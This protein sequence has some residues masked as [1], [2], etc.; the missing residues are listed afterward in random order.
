[1][2]KFTVLLVVISIVG[3]LAACTEN[4]ASSDQADTPATSQAT[5][6][7]PTTDTQ[8]QSP[9]EEVLD[10]A[11]LFQKYLSSCIN[12][13]HYSFTNDTFS[14]KKEYRIHS[15]NDL[16]KDGY[17]FVDVDTKISTGVT[18]VNELLEQGWELPA[19]LTPEQ[20]IGANID[21][22]S[23]ELT[24]NGHTIRV[25]M[26]N[27]TDASVSLKDAKISHITL[28]Q[29]DAHS[30][31]I[32]LAEAADFSIDGIITHNSTLQNIVNVYSEPTSISFHSDLL[33]I[34]IEYNS[35]VFN[36]SVDGNTIYNIQWF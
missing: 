20:K 24:K 34:R 36:I 31:E 18:T 30:P 13:D 12:I 19:S 10:D 27:D 14:L 21:V 23:P 2:K 17:I 9:T 11:A 5:E 25:G 3:T 33:Y 22:S 29:Y 7:L 28:E 26:H 16:P 32:R 15:Y 4:P 1:M 35:L 8:E 6:A